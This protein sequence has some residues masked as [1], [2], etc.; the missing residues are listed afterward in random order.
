[1]SSRITLRPYMP[2]FLNTQQQ[3]ANTPGHVEVEDNFEEYERE[4]ASLSAGFKRQVSLGE[5]CGIKYRGMPRYFHRGNNELGR[6]A[7]EMEIPTFDRSAKTFARAWVQKFDAYL[8]LNPMLE[9]DAIK[10]ATLYL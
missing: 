4:Y 9:M 1:M 3:D 10:F 5:Y 6:K 7:G 8:Q 2:C